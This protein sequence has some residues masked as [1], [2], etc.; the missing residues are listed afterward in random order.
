MSSR[1]AVRLIQS[2]VFYAAALL[3]LVVVRTVFCGVYKP[4]DVSWSDCLPALWMGLRVDA[5]WT[6]IL[7]APAWGF[8]LLSLW[9]PVFWRVAKVL[10]AVGA[11]AML[12]VA[13]VNFG[14][15][16][17]YGTPISPIIFGFLQ[18]DTKAIIAT[19][20]KDWPVVRYLVVFAAA[21]CFAPACAWGAGRLFS[22]CGAAGAAA[23]C[24]GVITLSVAALVMTVALVGFIRG[25]F[26]KF[27]LRQQNYAVSTHAFVNAA[28][29]GGAASLYEAWKGQKALDLRGGAAAALTDMG[30]RTKQEAEDVL[31]AL[32][33]P[34]APLPVPAEKPH[35]VFAVM[36]SMGR[37]IFES[38]HLPE[39]DTLG[40]LAPE[41]EDAVVFRNAVSVENGT[42]P[43]LEGLLFDTPLTPLT[44]SRYGRQTFPFSKVLDFKRAGYKVV[45]LTAGTE[46][47]RQVDVNFP[48]QGFDQVIGAI[49]LAKDFP[50][51]EVGTW[52]IGDKWM[53]K[54]A[55][56]LL[57]EADKKGEKLFLLILSATNHPP[58]R[59]PDGDE[60]APVD[61]KALP[62][63][64]DR[65]DPA[66]IRSMMETYQ[67]S[68]NAL[69]NFVHDVRTSALG[70]RTIIAATGDHNSRL[71]YTSPEYLQHMRG[72]P[73]LFWLPD[74]WS[75]VKA[76]ADTN[77]WAGH[78]DMF[79]TLKGLAL[80]LTPSL[81]EGRNLFAK[82]DF[83]LVLSFSSLS[84]RGFAIGS[85]GAVGLDAGGAF[86][87]L[88]W[89]GER[90]VGEAVCS[91]EIKRMGDAA[92][93][94]RALADY[95]VRSGVLNR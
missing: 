1:P 7:L 58:H 85:W 3:F 49:E 59:V 27:P 64:V 83:D 17:F 57:A 95:T 4:A 88:R 15:Y 74:A 68:S 14:Y 54:K 30:F 91:P 12:V 32:R 43:S 29:P 52:G 77:R 48:L 33:R 18:D 87:C 5:K 93:A 24:R 79:P 73:L 84:S 23:G 28:V 71:S 39:N 34:E 19:I 46:T 9:K 61:I 50:E 82:D 51:A 86:S 16:A 60:T 44:Q 75:A 31:A 13:V 80:G 40:A 47:W 35:V 56:A 8:V 42:F 78:R 67:Y 55:G 22:G 92:R 45:Y 70:G 11:A 62:A 63:F 38:H 94:E 53:F 65:S 20:W 10:G 69:G 72:V 36:E 90:L 89:E 66:L 37:D 2:A 41:L 25:S 21:L 26:G 81:H 76:D 6:G